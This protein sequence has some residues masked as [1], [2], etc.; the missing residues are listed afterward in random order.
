MSTPYRLP[1]DYPAWM[2][3]LISYFIP[4]RSKANEP[5]G[6]S[7]FDKEAYREQISYPQNPMRSVGELSKLLAVMRI[8]LPKV[9]VPVQLIHSKDD[10]Y[11]LSDNMEHIYAGLVNAP[12]K[13][14]LYIT[15]SGHVVTRD[16]ARLEVFE[17]AGQ[18]I[19][20]VEI[21]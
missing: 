8:A 14:K 3:R 10:R 18:F 15:G 11:V 12:D 19:R 5:P 20:R 13:Q 4:Y 9:N 7:W 6:S 21:A 1:V 16:A 17:A 2:F